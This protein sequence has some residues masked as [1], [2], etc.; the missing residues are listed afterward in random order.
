MKTK[1]FIGTCVENPFHRIETLCEIVDN[2]R[3]ITK[4]TFLSHCFVHP[5]TL[6]QMKQYP[7]D[8]EYYKYKNIYFYTWSAIE[9]FFD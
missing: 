3:E 9:Y 2:A 6:A 5:E 4:E 1:E 7:H 8:Y